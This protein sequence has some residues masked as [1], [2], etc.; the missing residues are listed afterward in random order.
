MKKIISVLLCFCMLFSFTTFAAAEDAPQLKVST[1]KVLA[2]DLEE[3]YCFSLVV[4]NCIKFESLELLITYNPDVLEYSKVFPYA[5]PD[6]YRHLISCTV[7]DAGK[8]RVT[9]Y[10][11][12]T[13]I[14]GHIEKIEPFCFNFIGT[15]DTDVAVELV[16][17][18][19][20]DGEVENVKFDTD[21]QN[22]TVTEL[23]IK[24]DLTGDGFVSSEDARLALRFAVGLDT[25][26][27][28]QRYAAGL[29]GD[30]EFTSALARDILRAAVGLPA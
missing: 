25:A 26:T 8:L 10:C 29:V 7:E 1:N 23:Y 12:D 27:D 30:G 17:F 15:G 4:K 9:A 6:E 28:A 22:F 21:I 24:Y 20:A 18:K 16:S 19:T 2:D 5:M 14:S 3:H 11:W 13:L